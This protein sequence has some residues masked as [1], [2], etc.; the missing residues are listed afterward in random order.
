MISSVFFVS[1][2]AIH[3]IDDFINDIPAEFNLSVPFTELLTF[4]YVFSIVGLIIGA[5][6]HSQTSFI[7]LS[8]AGLLITAAQLTKSFPEILQPGPWRSGF[9][10]V[11]IVIGLTLSAMV[12]MISSFMSWGLAKSKNISKIKSNQTPT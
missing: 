4:F 1:F 2:S 10:S 9:S 8:I 6:K 11:Q 3:L 7:G 12:L 5:A